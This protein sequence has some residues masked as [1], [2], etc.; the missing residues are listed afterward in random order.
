MDISFPDSLRTSRFP[1]CSLLLL[2]SDRQTRGTP[3]SIIT[4]LG[5]L[6]ERILPTPSG[7]FDH[8]LRV[9]GPASRR[10]TR[11]V[12]ILSQTGHYGR[13]GRTVRTNDG[14]VFCGLVPHD[15]PP[16]GLDE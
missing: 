10:R 13:A 5:G 16:L 15:T 6:G 2:E 3:S 12:P 1:D 9:F 14:I 8:E 11:S 4:S 7:I